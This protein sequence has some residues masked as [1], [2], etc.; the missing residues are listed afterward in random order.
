MGQKLRELV[1]Q[2]MSGQ[3]KAV[4][5]GLYLY[6][7]TRG[8]SLAYT[9]TAPRSGWFRFAIWGAGGG[10]VSS[11]G[12]G[13]A[14]VVA[15]RPLAK[16]QTVALVVA[17]GDTGTGIGAA[18]T[19]TFPDGSVVRAGGGLPGTAA[20]GVAVGDVGRGDILV[21]GSAGAPG[22]P[23]AAASYATYIGGAAGTPGLPEG[24]V[25][26]GG[27]YGS[28]AGQGGSGVAVVSQVRLRP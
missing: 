9:F 5:P 4:S 1:G 10:G 12:S 25:P 24:N 26:G 14:L 15:E 19:A 8:G 11:V 2:G 6:T 13:A 20:G 28:G 23:G 17:C 27:N 21:N 18:S 16:G 7:T 3:R 22:A